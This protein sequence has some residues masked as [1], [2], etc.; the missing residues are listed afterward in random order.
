MK[1]T[2]LVFAATIM[3]V[4]CGGNGNVETPSAVDSAIMADSIS[5]ADSSLTATDSTVAE[6]KE[7]E[8]GAEL[9]PTTPSAIK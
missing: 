3:L 4:A 7:G 8:N 2:M 5:V 1:K 6:I 9:V